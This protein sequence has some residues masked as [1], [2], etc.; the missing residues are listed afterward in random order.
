[1]IALEDRLMEQQAPCV[2]PACGKSW[3]GPMAAAL[4]STLG[5]PDGSVRVW[6]EECQKKAPRRA[7]DP[8]RERLPD[9][10]ALLC[11]DE[12]RLT[13]EGGRTER[14][15]LKRAWGLRP[16]GTTRLSA[17]QIAELILTK[18]PVLLGGAPGTLKTRLAWRM[19]RM[20]WDS[21]ATVRCFTSWRFQ[22]DL[23]E[24]SGAH[25]AGKWMDELSR[26]DLVLIDD[27]GK[28]EWTANTH[29]AFFE[30]F[31]ARI[32]R[33]KA[34]LITTNET[35]GSMEESRAT[36]KAAVAQSSAAPLIRRFREYAETV[37]MQRPE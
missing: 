14:E 30:M 28:A 20:L 10:W 16:N 24:A 22:S 5:Q 19:V 1:M 27:L 17:G 35:F 13:T 15:R 6:C 7:A 26:V 34:T 3:T 21:K 18:R 32:T 2:C 36:H 23:Q 33:T 11:P 37:V 9:P 29:G 31:E 4:I 25:C 12:Y 8:P